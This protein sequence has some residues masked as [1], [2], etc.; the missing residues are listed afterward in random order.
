MSN[1]STSAT[2]PA[3]SRTV[4]WVVGALVVALTAVVVG[5]V[6]WVEG[7]ESDADPAMSSEAI[8][9][10]T[11]IPTGAGGVA[12]TVNDGAPLL[13]VYF[14]PMCSYCVLLDTVNHDTFAQ[15][16]DDGEVTLVYHP[17]SFMETGFDGARSDMLAAAVA[18]VAHEAPEVLDAFVATLMEY[19][20][21]TMN[22]LDAEGLRVV[23]V[24]AGVP[25]DVI[26]VLGQERY[27][28]WVQEAADEME[29]RSGMRATPQLWLDG[30]VLE[31]DWMD[32]QN[33]VDAVRGA[34]A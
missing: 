29:A 1:M 19:Q 30:Q 26:A 7:R 8:T 23:A 12:G 16:R 27:V 28:Q 14:D 2:A 25:Q 34:G 22:E 17:V 21:L 20:A 33:V 3:R 24:N 11:G 4:G 13:E 18:A 31:V 5:L 9:P 6:M 32:P 10:A 15:L